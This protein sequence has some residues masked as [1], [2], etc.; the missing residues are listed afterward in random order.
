MVPDYVSGFHQ[1][2]NNVRALLDVTADQE[3]C[4]VNIV[5]G[6]DSRRRRV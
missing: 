1:F 4:G 5:P 2:T 6:Q 3:K